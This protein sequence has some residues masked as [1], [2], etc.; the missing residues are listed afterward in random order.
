MPK[1]NTPHNALRGPIDICS[2]DH[3][4]CLTPEMWSLLLHLVLEPLAPRS[5]KTAPCEVPAPDGGVEGV[6]Q[7]AL[8]ALSWMMTEIFARLGLNLELLLLV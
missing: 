6:S 1:A 5:T 2:I 4:Q 3:L 8:T 7:S